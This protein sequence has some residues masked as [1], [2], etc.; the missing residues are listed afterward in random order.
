[1]AWIYIVAVKLESSGC[2]I[3]SIHV[4][5]VKMAG[6]EDGQIGQEMRGE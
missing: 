1:M 2:L 6:S 5:E 3:G 4:L